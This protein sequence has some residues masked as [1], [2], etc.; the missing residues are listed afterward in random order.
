MS[1]RI[2][3]FIFLSVVL[4]CKKKDEVL[5]VTPTSNSESY[6]FKGEW[7]GF[8]LALTGS[9]PIIG[10]PC[11]MTHLY[12]HYSDT[13]IDTSIRLFLE[14]LPSLEDTL[15]PKSSKGE[16]YYRTKLTGHKIRG[17]GYP[18]LE[19]SFLTNVNGK[20][21]NGGFMSHLP[22]ESD[23]SYVFI[24]DLKY[25][26]TKNV[27]DSWHSYQSEIYNIKGMLYSFI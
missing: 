8:E 7:R 1:F 4:S 2:T 16:S 9:D 12:L 20:P 18:T 25:S 21:A 27:S 15:N 13:T 26:T 6:Y 3:L 24:T 23:S 5:P 17:S 14:L 10:A 19:S 22:P 11:P